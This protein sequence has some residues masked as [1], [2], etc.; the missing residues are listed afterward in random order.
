M[1][2]S[3]P[4]VSACFYLITDFYLNNY[5]S[6]FLFLWRMCRHAIAYL[7]CDQASGLVIF[8]LPVWEG[9]AEEA[10]GIDP[11][12]GF[13]YVQ[14]SERDEQCRVVPEIVSQKVSSGSTRQDR[15]WGETL[16]HCPQRSW[17]W[18]KLTDPRVAEVGMLLSA[19]GELLNH[20]KH[21]NGGKK[22]SNFLLVWFPE[23]TC[24]S[25]LCVHI[26]MCTSTD[27]PPAVKHP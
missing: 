17:W 21:L 7:H 1:V 18:H 11:M 26:C 12:Q 8:K 14:S 20:R 16:L 23:A 27:T 3:V 13:S 19:L 25:Y 5:C 24:C 9:A 4:F 22:K 6:V 2:D 15:F 10:E